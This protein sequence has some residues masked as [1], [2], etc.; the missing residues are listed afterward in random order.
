MD[1]AFF[2][3]L[4]MR[5]GGC[6]GKACRFS[7]AYVIAHEVGHHVQNQLGLLGRV[8][9]LQRESGSR[10]DANQLQVRG[11]SCR[12]TASPAC[13]RAAPRRS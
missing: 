6:E 8:Q 3:D 10:A 2:R 11:S 12:P 4:E 9:E 5:F 7:Q 1:T 13:G